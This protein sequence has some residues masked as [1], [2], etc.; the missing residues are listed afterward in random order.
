MHQINR[1]RFKWSGHFYGSWFMVSRSQASNFH[2]LNRY[3]AP[4]TSGLLSNSK[5]SDVEDWRWIRKQAKNSL[6]VEKWIADDN[7]SATFPLLR[8]NTSTVSSYELAFGHPSIKLTNWLVW[9][10]T[11]NS[12]GKC[13]EIQTSPILV[14]THIKWMLLVSYIWVSSNIPLINAKQQQ[15]LLLWQE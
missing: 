8:F 13:L 7:S 2:S 10:E 12:V 5:S 11:W 9:C 3:S 4:R 15:Q 6:K 14:F 1:Q